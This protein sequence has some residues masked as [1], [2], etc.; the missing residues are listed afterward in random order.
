MQGA[1]QP[2]PANIC[3]DIHC[4]PAMRNQSPHLGSSSPFHLGP[5]DVL[6]SG[7]VEN[8]GPGAVEGKGIRLLAPPL[9]TMYR[10][11]EGVLLP[12]PRRTFSRW[13]LTGQSLRGNSRGSK[14]S[15]EAR[16]SPESS[17]PWTSHFPQRH[18]SHTAPLCLCG[19]KR[20]SF[21]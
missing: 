15:P 12:R 5:L 19:C 10:R 18:S 16:L 1:V 6:L 11:K 4:W 7:L 2:K 17:G 14:A 9:E 21:R 20:H 3:T 13:M 8:R